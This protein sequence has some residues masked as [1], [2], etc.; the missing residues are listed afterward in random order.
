MGYSFPVLLL[1]SSIFAIHLTQLQ[2]CIGVCKLRMAE[3][4]HWASLRILAVPSALPRPFRRRRRGQAWLVA[5]YW[6]RNSVSWN[7]LFH[8]RFY[9]TWRVGNIP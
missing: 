3:R 7:I 5:V 1:S 9:F 8:C 4:E 2:G 6:V